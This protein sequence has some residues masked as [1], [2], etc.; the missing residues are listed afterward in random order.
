MKLIFLGT[1]HGIP[2][3]SRFCSSAALEVDGKLYLIDAGAP[4]VD[5]LL[6][7]KRHP[8]AIRAVFCTHHHGDH[9]DGL[10]NLTDL[11]GWAYKTADFD[12]YVTREE[13]A[14]LIPACVALA[15]NFTSPAYLGAL[16]KR[17][18]VLCQVG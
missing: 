14:E 12:V 3:E 7:C 17:Y 13:Q 2:T 8:G 1:S 4:I 10:L 11:C 9:T 16:R 6:R 18:F 15:S 5:M